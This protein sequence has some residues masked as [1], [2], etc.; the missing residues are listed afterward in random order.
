[1]TIY[2][3]L[4]YICLGVQCEFFQSE[5]YTLDEKKCEQEITQQK[6]ELIK[7]GRKVEA[8]CVDVDI[9]L[10]R[11]TNEFERK[12]YPEGTNQVRYSH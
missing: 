1:V 4:L 12:L 8:I 9:K 3:P 7:Q 10:E 11:Q 5:S 6:S 2:I